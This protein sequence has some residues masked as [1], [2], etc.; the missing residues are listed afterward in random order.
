MWGG[1]VALHLYMGNM[2]DSWKLILVVVG[3]MVACFFVGRITKHAEQIETI[4][5]KTDT[6]TLWD[7]V[8]IDRP[9]PVIQRVIDTMYVALADTVSVH[10]TTF[11]LLP[12]TQREYQDSL[13][14]AWIS[15]YRPQLDSI[16]VYTPTKF[17]TKT[18]MEK[19][20]K[21][22]IGVQVGYGVGKEGLSP[23]V[24]LGLTY[25]LI[26]F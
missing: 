20:K 26:G 5:H 3:L 12:R 21:W 10:D 15:G 22:H 16:E 7:T 19:P 17:I 23:Y 8:R 24:G 4:V 6:L 2:K 9:V 25:S 13:Y 1:I 14:H 11:V 18:I